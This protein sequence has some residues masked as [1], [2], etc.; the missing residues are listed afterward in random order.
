[1]GDAYTN[2]YEMVDENGETQTITE[3]YPANRYGHRAQMSRCKAIGTIPD[4]LINNGN[5][6][7]VNGDTVYDPTPNN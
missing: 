3:E 2:T 1:M 7:V 6:S 5:A 4:S